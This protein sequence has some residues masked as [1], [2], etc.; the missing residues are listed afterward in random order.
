MKPPPSSGSWFFGFRTLLHRLQSTSRLPVRKYLRV[1]LPAT[2]HHHPFAGTLRACSPSESQSTVPALPAPPEIALHTAAG[3]LSSG[4]TD[5]PD[6]VGPP[7]GI[8]DGH[9]RKSFLRS[10]ATRFLRCD[11]LPQ[12]AE[13]F[14]SSAW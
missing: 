4:R 7:C 9:G 14:P 12:L 11:H 6:S 2:V 5:R 3:D 1:C 13:R 8:R 10:T